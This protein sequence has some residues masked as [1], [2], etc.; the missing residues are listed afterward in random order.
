VVDLS[1]QMNDPALL[2]ADFVVAANDQFHLISDGVNKKEGKLNA[3]TI[4]FQFKE[5]LKREGK[6]RK[7][8][9]GG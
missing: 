2:E 6:R 5:W 4:L 9:T 1:L 8:S 7:M 3:D